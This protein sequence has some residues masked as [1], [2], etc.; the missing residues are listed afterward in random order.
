MNHLNRLELEWTCPLCDLQQAGS[1]TF[2]YGRCYRRVFQIGENIDWNQE[3]VIETERFSDGNGEIRQRIECKGHW[4]TRWYAE[5]RGSNNP[6]PTGD[7]RLRY[8]CIGVMTIIIQLA[9]DRISGFRFPKDR[10]ELLA[11][12]EPFNFLAA[13]WDCPFCKYSYSSTISPYITFSYGPYD[14]A[15]RWTPKYRV[16][17]KIDWS[18]SDP[19]G[20][21]LPNGSGVIQGKAFCSNH[22]MNHWYGSTHWRD[23]PIEVRQKY[24]CPTF[25]PVDIQINDDRLEK[26]SFPENVREEARWE[27][28]QWHWAF[29][30]HIC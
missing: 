7:E 30:G 18:Q 19:L 28:R 9:Q 5:N 21:R 24:G 4:G 29:T 8:G 15:A 12:P 11:P 17:D 3:G 6:Q 26:I 27:G 1:V 16:G 23:V 20:K 2:P 22:W 14:G 25:I 10:F 13:A